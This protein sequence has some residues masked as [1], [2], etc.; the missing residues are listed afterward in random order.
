M[1]KHAANKIMQFH[2]HPTKAK[3]GPEG[4]PRILGLTA[5]PIV[6]SKSQELEYVCIFISF[7]P[8]LP[9]TMLILSGLS[10]AI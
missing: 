3:D 1:R 5:S 2:Y 4:V 6:R 8:F 10:R 9:L 7:L